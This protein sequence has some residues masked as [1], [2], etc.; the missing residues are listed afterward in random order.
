MIYFLQNNSSE[1]SM[2]GRNLK[3]HQNNIVMD[4]DPKLAACSREEKTMTGCCISNICVLDI[5]SA[6]K[7]TNYVVKNVK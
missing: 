3:S 5:T 7:Y 4:M 2:S 6:T 1:Q